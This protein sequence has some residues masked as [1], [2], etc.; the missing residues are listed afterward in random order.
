MAWLTFANTAIRLDNITWLAL[1]SKTT[2]FSL[3][4]KT[5]L[6]LA[7]IH[8]WLDLANKMQS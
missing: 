2:W 1:G 8:T 7:N 4:E 3:A 5:W 6:T